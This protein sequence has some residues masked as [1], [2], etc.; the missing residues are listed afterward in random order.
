ML[1]TLALSPILINLLVAGF[2]IV[3]VVL[4]LLVLIQRPECGGVLVAQAAEAPYGD[5][6]L[7]G[8][9][10][11]GHPAPMKTLGLLN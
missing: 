4:I 8:D 5:S 10:R 11:P 7:L 1:T 2:L 9:G 3:C 6:E